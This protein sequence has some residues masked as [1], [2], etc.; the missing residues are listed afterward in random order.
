MAHDEYSE[1]PPGSK[2]IP[3]Y[4]LEPTPLGLFGTGFQPVVIAFGNEL[5][6]ISIVPAGRFR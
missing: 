1:K 3:A 6:T 5:P 4:S 2:L